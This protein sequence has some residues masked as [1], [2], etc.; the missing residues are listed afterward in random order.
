MGFLSLLQNEPAERAVRFLLNANGST[1]L[2]NLQR[3]RNVDRHITMHQT[4]NYRLMCTNII[5]MKSEVAVGVIDSVVSGARKSKNVDGWDDVF[6]RQLFY[7]GQIAYL[8]LHKVR[9]LGLHTNHGLHQGCQLV[10]RMR[11]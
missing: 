5:K 1:G 6:D 4:E 9:S 3:W 11:R 7:R 2:N 8:S 10:I